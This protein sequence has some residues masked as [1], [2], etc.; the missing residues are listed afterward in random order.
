MPKLN[1]ETLAARLDV[2][3]VAR[4]GMVTGAERAAGRGSGLSQRADAAVA[5]ELGR[6]AECAGPGLRGKA[7]P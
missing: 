2:Q 7:R 5:G 1:L 6:A 4:Q 3:A